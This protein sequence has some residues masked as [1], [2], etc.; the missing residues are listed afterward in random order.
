MLV[1]LDE[2][3]RR[4]V[5]EGNLLVALSVRGVPLLI[6]AIQEALAERPPSFDAL[7]QAMNARVMAYAVLSA[8][9]LSELQHLT[10]A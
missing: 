9:D 10:G 3:R 6:A 2:S 8:E 7:L 5:L 1:S 4:A